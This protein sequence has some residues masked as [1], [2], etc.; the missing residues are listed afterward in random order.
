MKLL[1]VGSEFIFDP[2]KWSRQQMHEDFTKLAKT[3][4][5][6]KSVARVPNQDPKYKI[7]IFASKQVNG[8]SFIFS[9]LVYA[10]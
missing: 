1:A 9:F 4:N 5:A 10:F 3:F 7:A 6:M 2:V 8:K